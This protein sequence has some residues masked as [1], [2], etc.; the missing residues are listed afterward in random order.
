[1]VPGNFYAKKE[2]RFCYVYLKQFSIALSTLK[3]ATLY[4]KEENISRETTT[5]WNDKYKL[6]Q[7]LDSVPVFF[8]LRYKI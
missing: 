2:F 1:M 7:K 4:I 6:L 8:F 3:H 5:A